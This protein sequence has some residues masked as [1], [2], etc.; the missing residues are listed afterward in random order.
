VKRGTP[1]VGAPS[2][3]AQYMP[4][5]HASISTRSHGGLLFFLFDLGHE[6]GVVAEVFVL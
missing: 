1:T 5:V 2:H 3:T 6:I 4:P